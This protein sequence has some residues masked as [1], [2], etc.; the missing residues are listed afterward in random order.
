MNYQVTI[1]PDAFQEIEDTY[2][3]LCDNLSPDLANKWFN[4]LQTAIASLATFPQRC[5]LSPEATAVGRE[6][7]QLIVGKKKQYRVLFIVQDQDV[8]V[9]HVRHSRQSRSI[10]ED[11]E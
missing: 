11:E 10:D 4:D 3:W 2:R 9:L 8:S 1:Q 6:V 7:R 5:S